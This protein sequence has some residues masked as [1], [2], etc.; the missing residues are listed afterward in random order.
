[1][2]ALRRSRLLRWLVPL[3]L[4]AALI[5]V[6]EGWAVPSSHP[7]LE[8]RSATQV[9]ASVRRGV[10][11]PRSGTFTLHTNLGLGQVAASASANQF[12]AL[13][14]G[15]NLGRVW[16]D[17]GQRSRV[18]LLQPLQ[19]TDWVRNPT[20]T[21]VWQ[22]TGTQA[23]RVRN[24]ASLDIP[25]LGAITSLVGDSSI[26]PPDVV[27]TRLLALRNDSMLSL[28]S[29]DI[30]AGRRV[31]E[32]IET[33]RS[34]S[35]LITNVRVSVDAATGLPLRVRLFVRGKSSPIIDDRYSAVSF[36]RPA[37]SNFE[38]RPPAHSTV[39]D[40]P[41]VGAALEP[42]WRV[43]ERQREFGDR[44][45][46][47]DSS[48]AFGFDAP[49]LAIRTVGSGWDEVIIASGVYRWGLREIFGSASDVTGPFG[50]GFLAR[51]SA[52]SVIVL[53][54]GRIAAGVVTPTRLKAALTEDAGR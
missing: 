15:S 48:A 9:A 29:P 34:H 37:A 53:D 26:E 10:A 42:A 28:G 13:A 31:Y 8:R 39:I 24:S 35:T 23:A 41:S 54:D 22:S 33:P 1:M 44:G 25:A 18:A 2:R 7:T 47:S 50:H 16:S 11:L 5:V 17:G 49:G 43:R 38:F 4:V 36:S 20:Q 19:E 40:A 6:A 45:F 32:L 51:T 52:V 12:V 30:V 3:A 21:W 46:G 14:S 27:A